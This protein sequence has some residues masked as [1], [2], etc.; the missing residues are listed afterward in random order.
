MSGC[1]IYH[2]LEGDSGRFKDAVPCMYIKHNYCIVR[3]IGNIANGNFAEILS[4]NKCTS[5]ISA[6]A[7]YKIHVTFKYIMELLTV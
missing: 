4:S 6:E 1:Y 2:F 7:L 5:A 3:G